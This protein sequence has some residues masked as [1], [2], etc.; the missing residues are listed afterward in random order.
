MRIV[1]ATNISDSVIFDVFALGYSDYFFEFKMDQETFVQRFLE[2]EA[3]KKY[4]FIAYDGDKPVGMVLGNIKNYEGV[5]TMRCGGFAVIPGYRS[6]GIGKELF[7]HHYRLA[8]EENCK[9]LFLEVL[10]QNVKAIKFYE[11]LGYNPVHDYRMYV[12][13]NLETIPAVANK[14]KAFVFRDLGFDTI[15]ELRDSMPELH[16]NWQG[17]IFTLEKFQNLH[18]IGLYQ[19]NKLVGAISYKESGLI[20][21]IWVDRDYRHLGYGRVL[22]TKCIQSIKIDKLIAI[23]ANNMVYEGFLRKL[24]FTVDIEQFEMI[25]PI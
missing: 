24:G 23:A 21:F 2:N 14:F 11:S 4:S 16:M 18:H 6:K 5:K 15:V 19:E 13:E 8:K 1:S 9:L 7:D 12:C 10:K 17:E 20:N 25:M 22:L 3:D